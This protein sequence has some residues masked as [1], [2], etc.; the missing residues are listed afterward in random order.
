M[1][2]GLPKVQPGAVQVGTD[3]SIRVLRVMAARGVLCILTPP[4]LKRETEA[5]EE[6]L[7]YTQEAQ[8][9]GG[10]TRSSSPVPHLREH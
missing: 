2:V 4:E 3:T 1:P 6:T 7:T 5:P 9:R 10:W 8:G